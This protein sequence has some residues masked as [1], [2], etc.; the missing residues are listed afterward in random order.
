MI[1]TLFAGLVMSVPLA[2][3]DLRPDLKSTA[4][5]LVT[6][7]AAIKTGDRVLIT[8]RAA[9]LELLEKVAIDVRKRGAFPL[10]TV[11]DDRLAR[12][13]YEATPPAFD[14]Q[15]DGLMLGLAGLVDAA[16]MV[17]AT[18]SPSVFADVPP[19]RMAALEGARRATE[20]AMLKHNVRMVALGNGLFPT[21]PVAKRHGVSVEELSSVF[22]NGVN[23][24][25]AKLQERGR[26]VQAKLMAGK[27]LRITNANGTDLRMS[28]AA[29]PAFVS[30]GVISAEDIARGGAACQVWL[31]AGE[32][33]GAPVPGSAEGTVVVDRMVY[34]GREIKGLTLLFKA[35]RLTSMS[36]RSGLEGL[37]AAYDAAGAGK[38]E[39]AFIDIGINPDVKVPAGSTMLS[40]VPAGMVSIGVG[41]NGWAGGENNAGFSAHFFLPGST[42]TVDGATVVEKGALRP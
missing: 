35:G 15:P 30:D 10:I 34:R 12:R 41:N 13:M 26:A 16:I 25:Y 24:D 17:D 11:S 20:A 21:E 37:K 7:C 28:F 33:F 5:T 22:W 29:R 4:E 14:A 6:Q 36:A 38:D 32:V 42:L 39:F 2:G 40:W 3:P 27:E 31:P 1:A 19:E 23:T 18:D 8:G 9:D